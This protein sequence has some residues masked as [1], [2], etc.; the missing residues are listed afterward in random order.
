MTRGG[1]RLAHRRSREIGEDFERWLDEQHA[2]AGARGALA[3][4]VHNAPPTK[5]VHG[6]LIYDEK[7][8]ADYTGI[9]HAGKYLAA[10]AKSVAPGERLAKKRVSPLQQAHL[11]AVES[12]GGLALLLVEF[13]VASSVQHHRYA[14]PWHQV[15]WK[16]VRTAES[17]DERD[18]AVVYQITAGTDY[19]MRYHAGSDKKYVIGTPQRAYP[20]E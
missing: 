17:L 2:K 16:V 1:D 7:G 13:R 15:P 10:E 11:D 9:L 8:V 14:I 3:H 12:A 19:L 18:V 5:V 4:V 6:K 20:R